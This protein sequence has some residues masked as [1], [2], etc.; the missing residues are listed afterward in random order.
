MIIKRP[1]TQLVMT[2]FCNFFHIKY[3][4]TQIK[5][6]SLVL[7]QYRNEYFPK[8]CIFW[9]MLLDLKKDITKSWD[10]DSVLYKWVLDY[11]RK[12]FWKMFNTEANIEYFA[13]PNCC[14]LT[15]SKIEI[16]IKFLKNV[17]KEG[18]NFSQMAVCE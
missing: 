5:Q 17:V 11:V 8:S 15:F 9:K 2:C 10:L 16:I 1:L 6:H 13:F 4:D 18:L 12:F 14:I 3:G 7:V